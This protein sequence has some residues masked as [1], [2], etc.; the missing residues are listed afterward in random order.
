MR[1]NRLRQTRSRA[2]PHRFSCT[3]VALATAAILLAPGAVATAAARVAAREVSAP[4][5]EA[6]PSTSQNWAGY[7]VTAHWPLRHVSG[8][9][10]Q[11]KVNCEGLTDRYS[12]FW[13]GLGGF[14]S[15]A[16]SLEQ[17]GT[18]ADCLDGQTSIYAWYELFP[19]N[20][21]R[22]QPKVQ[23]GDRISAAVTVTGTRVSIDL[24]DL[25]SGRGA[26][27][28]LRM[29][30]PE[31]SSAE[32]IAEAP[33][34]CVGASRC[35]V[36]PLADFSSITFEEDRVSN[37]DGLLGTIA[38]PAL[39]VTSLLLQSQPAHSGASTSALGG[40]ATDEAAPSALAGTGSSFTV[41]W[42]RHPS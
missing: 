30:E 27:R 35:Q 31:T 25:T 21:V 34:E 28:R 6:T 29:V 15:H 12:A 40:G 8:A 17:V 10:V 7:A 18:E 37:G 2:R 26:S 16:R 24:R 3:L 20:A 41:T 32:W 38:D 22:L 13:V 14:T 11:P 39:S 5:I 4:S 33:S 9:W 36:L 1:T 23:S 42:R 19:A